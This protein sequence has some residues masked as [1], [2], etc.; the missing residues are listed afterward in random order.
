MCYETRGTAPPPIPSLPPRVVGQGARSPGGWEASD[1]GGFDPP[2]VVIQR[3][4]DGEK[5]LGPL[6]IEAEI[7]DRVVRTSPGE[8]ALLIDELDHLH[9]PAQIDHITARQLA[10]PD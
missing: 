10:Q 4:E 8:L 2:I 5:Q 7:V 3:L 6:R 9:D 1:R